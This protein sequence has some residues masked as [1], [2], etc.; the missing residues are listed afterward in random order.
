MGQASPPRVCHMQEIAFEPHQ[1]E[2]HPVDDW[3]EDIKEPSHACDG[4][5]RSPAS[6]AVAGACGRIC[7]RHPGE[8][9][10]V[11]EVLVV[12]HEALQKVDFLLR[13]DELNN[14]D[15]PAMP[16]V[17]AAVRRA[18]IQKKLQIRQRAHVAA[19]NGDPISWEDD[20]ASTDPSDS[21]DAVAAL[22]ELDLLV[23][24]ATRCAP[25]VD[26]DFSRPGPSV[27]L[28]ELERKLHHGMEVK[29]HRVGC[30]GR[31]AEEPALLRLPGGEAFHFRTLDGRSVDMRVPMHRLV[32]IDLEESSG[33]LDPP[34]RQPPPE[35]PPASDE[36]VF[37]YLTSSLCQ[38]AWKAAGFG[39]GY[40]MTFRFERDAEDFGLW[41]RFFYCSQVRS[42][43][44]ALL[45]KQ[46]TADEW[47]PCS[48]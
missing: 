43:P 21:E 41:M 31:H 9:G 6:A 26:Y 3:S 20:L 22:A 24:G 10:R 48:D 47:M 8:A 7:C 28:A 25:S 33:Y 46:M 40:H 15:A 44:S 17:V 45:P 29:L 14:C 4:D 13:H 30:D 19:A 35:P 39:V 37:A 42:V 32:A 2:W 16:E 18:K 36:L 1:N 34:S 38:E 27:P 12:H 11:E 5:E 23:Q